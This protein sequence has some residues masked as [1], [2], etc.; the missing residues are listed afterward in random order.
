MRCFFRFNRAT[1]DVG[2]VEPSHV[3]KFVKNHP[4]FIFFHRP[5]KY[6]DSIHVDPFKGIHINGLW[7]RSKQV[8][9][10]HIAVA[11]VLCRLLSGQFR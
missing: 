5:S 8:F 9:G 1:G 11:T 7:N 3:V 2:N 4:L 6:I 10:G